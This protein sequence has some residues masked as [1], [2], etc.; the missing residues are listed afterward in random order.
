MYM[1]IYKNFC[2]AFN[3]SNSRKKYSMEH[4]QVATCLLGA[5]FVDEKAHEKVHE[6]SG[7]GWGGGGVFLPP[8]SA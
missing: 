1:Y 3:T 4:S 7:E 2:T 6:K 5:G 8:Y